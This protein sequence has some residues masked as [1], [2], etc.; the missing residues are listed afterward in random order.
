MTKLGLGWCALL[1]FSLLLSSGC[2]GG[3][4]G[5]GG[6]CTPAADTCTGEN[7]CILGACE[8]AF[9]RIYSITDVTV[10]VPTADGTGAS[11]DALGGAPD[12]FIVV[13]VNGS[14]IVTSATRDDVFSASFFGPYDAT[15]VGGSSLAIEVWDADV[16]ANDLMF[17]CQASPL[18][19]DLLRRHSLSCSSGGFTV[20]FQIDPR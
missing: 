19:A 20:A 17:T 15:I 7:I 3:G 13:T 11:W 5:P 2:G 4:P 8:A 6:G 16:S 1:W 10:S 12:P 18:S 9:G 14:S